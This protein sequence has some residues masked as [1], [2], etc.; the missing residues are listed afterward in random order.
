ML[1][2][3]CATIFFSFFSTMMYAVIMH[4]KSRHPTPA[5]F[6]EHVGVE[7]ALTVI[8][9]IIVIA[10]AL[11]ATR[12]VVAMKDTTSADLTVKV[13]GYQW[14]WG[15]EYVDGPAQGVSFLSNLTTPR[16]EEHT[17]ELQSRGHLVCRLLL[18]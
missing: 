3:I 5:K 2:I 11:P 14:K 4:R 16:S 13:T 6:H 1:F 9:F 12:T 18:E 10:M 15:Y 7:V 8:P 17:S